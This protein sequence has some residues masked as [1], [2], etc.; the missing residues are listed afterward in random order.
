MSW[1]HRLTARPAGARRPWPR[2]RPL[3]Q[4]LEER[5]VTGGLAQ[6]G[7]GGWG[8]GG[9]LGA[10]G[11]L[12]N[13]GTLDLLDVTLT[14]N[15]ASGGHGGGQGD[16]SNSGGGIGSDAAVGVPGGFGGGFVPT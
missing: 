8:G 11:A 9:G 4:E 7:R 13:Q 12:F 15:R 10:G 16:P 6:G 5:L 3:L 2:Y 14:N 1:L